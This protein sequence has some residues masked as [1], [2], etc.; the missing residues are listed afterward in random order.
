MREAMKYFGNIDQDKENK[1]GHTN[2]T[3]TMLNEF[4]QLLKE[5]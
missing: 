2:I 4:I 1:G 3:N 5:K